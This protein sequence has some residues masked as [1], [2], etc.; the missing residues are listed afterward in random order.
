M[1]PERQ[2][3]AVVTERPGMQPSAVL[4]AGWAGA[5]ALSC[6]ESCFWIGAVCLSGL[7]AGASDALDEV[8]KYAHRTAYVDAAE[9]VKARTEVA[10]R[11]EVGSDPVM[12]EVHGFLFTAKD[13]VEINP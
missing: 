11:M 5:D 4:T 9:I 6:G 1:W 2:L 10:A 3:A 7:G 12:E 8:L 13:R